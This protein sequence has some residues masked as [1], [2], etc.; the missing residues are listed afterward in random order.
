MT[1]FSAAAATLPDPVAVEHCDVT[2]VGG[3]GHV[4]IPLVLALAEAGLRVN[5]NDTGNYR[6][7]PWISPRHHATTSSTVSSKLTSVTKP[8]R[9]FAFVTSG[10]RY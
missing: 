9:S 3:A 10:T 7:P 5:V 4:G 2:V 1:T 8:S 6:R